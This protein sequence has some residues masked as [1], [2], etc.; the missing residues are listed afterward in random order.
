M[1][2][3]KDIFFRF[4]VGL[5]MGEIIGI[6]VNVIISLGVG[7]GQYIAAM[8]QLMRWFNNEISAVIMQYVLV[9]AIG[10]VFAE[11]AMVFNI[12]SWSFLKKCIVH[13][14]I[15]IVFYIPFVYLCYMPQNL[16]SVIIMLINFIFTYAL[17][18]FIQYKVNCKDVKQINERIQEVR[19]NECNRD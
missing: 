12:E 13:F 17:T 11:S 2:M 10:V 18:W 3:K 15:S 9:G 14:G 7:H 19:N 16:K 4:W 6:L 5:S 8:P 1:A